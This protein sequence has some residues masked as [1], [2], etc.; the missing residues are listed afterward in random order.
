[1]SPKISK[2]HL[3][4]AQYVVNF[5]NNTDK[6]ING[7][8]KSFGGCRVAKA[9]D[10]VTVYERNKSI[11]RITCHQD[12]SY[13]YE[14]MFFNAVALK[15]IAAVFSKLGLDLMGIH[16]PRTGTVYMTKAN[17]TAVRLNTGLHFTYEQLQALYVSQD[18]NEADD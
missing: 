10:V 14:F 7:N 11:V 9:H 1:M 13:K 4:I 17:G 18:E 6:F 2:T 15:R 3:T 5:M 16:M 12:G 8:S